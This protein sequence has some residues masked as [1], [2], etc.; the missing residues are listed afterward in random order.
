MKTGLV[1]EGGAMRGLFSAGVIDVMMEQGVAFDTLIGVSAGAAFGCNYKSG[2]I[3][4]A[5]RYN[6]R[7]AQDKRY[8]SR[9]SLLRTGNLFGAEFCYHT[10]PNRLDL[11]DRKTFHDSPMKFYVVCTDI[12]T[13]MPVYHRCDTANDTC[14]EW[15][16]A[17]ASMPLVSTPVCLDGSLLLDGGISDSIPLQYMMDHGFE[18]N[19]VVL[20]QPRSYVKRPASMMALLRMKL[21]KYPQLLRTMGERHKDYNRSRRLVFAGERQGNVFV[22]CPDEP[23]P[24][25][26][27]EHDPEN[28]HR[29]YQLGRAVAERRLEALKDFMNSEPSVHTEG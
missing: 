28:M 4:R 15:I 21:R 26:R 16:R 19:V 5:I 20:T 12:Q 22:I 11:F 27:I 1:L 29:V 3:G 7:F 10:I 6:M 18:K 25:G 14:Y 23:L 17:S 8:C 2:Q 13:G 9:W 24:I